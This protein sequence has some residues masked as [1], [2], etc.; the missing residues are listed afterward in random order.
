VARNKT[1]TE[2]NVSPRLLQAGLLIVQKRKREKKGKGQ[3]EKKS[4]V[5]GNKTTSAHCCFKWLFS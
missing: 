4:P 2:E 3:K 5:A 1:Q